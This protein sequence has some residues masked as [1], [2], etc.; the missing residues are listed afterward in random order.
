MT[1][2]FDEISTFFMVLMGIFGS[3][4]LI[5]NVI[6]AITN[7]KHKHDE[8]VENIDQ[9]VDDLEDRMDKVEEKLDGD[10]DFRQEE[11]EFNRVVLH[12]M[13]QILKTLN[14]M[15]DGDQNKKQLETVDGEIDKYLIDHQG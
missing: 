9:R 13:K 14:H 4:V 12:S 10:W 1:Y 15:A 6:N 2:G 11:V 8:P 3:I 7:L 5:T